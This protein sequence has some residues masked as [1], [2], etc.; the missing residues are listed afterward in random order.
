MKEDGSATPEFIYRD[1]S[2][3]GEEI[4]KAEKP[5]FLDM[6]FGGQAQT[7]SKAYL[8]IDFGTSTT[9]VS[10]VDESSIQVWQRRSK[11]GNWRELMT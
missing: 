4:S 8:G 9:A 6:T 5:F 3:S 2:D 1:K 7:N 10:Y 11:E